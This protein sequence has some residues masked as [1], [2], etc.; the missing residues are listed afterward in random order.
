MWVRCHVIKPIALQWKTTQGSTKIFQRQ[1][2]VIVVVY[3]NSTVAAGRR[4]RHDLRSCQNRE[5]QPDTRNTF[6]YLSI[7]NVSLIT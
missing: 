5:G 4:R 3:L 6:A 2:Y 7:K 1:K